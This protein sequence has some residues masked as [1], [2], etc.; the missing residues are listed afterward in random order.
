V[1]NIT[2]TPEV[3]YRWE[4][5]KSWDFQALMDKARGL[6]WEIH[7]RRLQFFIPGQ[8]Y[9]MG[10]RGRYPAIS[11]TGASCALNCDHCH[12]KILEG[13]IPAVEP[14]ALQEVCRQLDVQG[15]TGVLLS[16]GSDMRGSLPWPKF[17]EAI[18]WVK[19]H[20]R[21]KI[22]IHTGLIE[23]TTALA[24]EE[25]GVDEV[26]I[27]VIGSESTLHQVYHLGE[28]LEVMESSLKALAA[29]RIPLIPHIVVGLHYGKI[30]GEMRA[31]EMV[32]QHPIT[33][34]VIV[35]L[36][37]MQQTPMDGLAPP[38]PEDV[39]RFVAAARL[40]LP[41]IPLSLS[42][43]RPLGQHRVE[44]DILALE[45]GVNRIAMP[46]EEAVEKAREMGLEIEFHKTCCSK[47]Y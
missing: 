39:A 2:V 30:K 29:T 47:S 38:E 7:G 22:T 27:D 20:T 26:L 18:Q 19:Q 34:L 45:A 46:A 32:A 14:E 17:L 9:Y 33:A 43:G 15:N 36:K 23:E 37:P 6:S 31:L 11:L 3:A 8:M 25:A 24:L 12:R 21:L 5:V 35:V 4:E 28:G 13:M 10:E 41:R 42:C 16:G 40:R 1:R 44:T